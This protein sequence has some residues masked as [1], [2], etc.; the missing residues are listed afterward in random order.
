MWGDPNIP[1]INYD[2]KTKEDGEVHRVNLSWK[3]DKDR[4]LYATYST[5]YRPGGNNRTPGINPYKA[6]TLTN[7]EIGAKTAWF[8]RT[9]FL[10]VAALHRQMERCA[11]WLAGPGRR[12]PA[13]TTQEMRA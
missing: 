11:I 10:N 12:R 5:G 7:F 13:P 6:D 2:R 8:D 1:C 4:M 3:V 9:L